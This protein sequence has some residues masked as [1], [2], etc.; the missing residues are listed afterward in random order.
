[1]SNDL[2]PLASVSANCAATPGVSPARRPRRWVIPVIVLVVLAVVAGVAVVVL[3]PWS[4]PVTWT[5]TLDD[6]DTE[7]R[8]VAVAED[9]SVV[10]VGF[11]TVWDSKGEHSREAPVITKLSADGRLL[12]SN[13]MSDNDLHMFNA[14]TIA[15]D[16]NYVVAGRAWKGSG[17][18]AII[19]CLSPDGTVVWTQALGEGMGNEFRGV[20]IAPDGSIVAVGHRHPDYSTGDTAT[21][22]VAKYTMDGT[23]VWMKGIAG[24]TAHD[25]VDF[26][27]VCSNVDGT[28]R[29]VGYQSGSHSIITKIASDGELVWTK[30]DESPASRSV[31]STADG[32]IVVAGRGVWTNNTDTAVATLTPDGDM[33]WIRKEAPW[34]H[35]WGDHT[36]GFSEMTIA[37]SGEI[38]IVGQSGREAGLEGREHGALVTSLKPDGTVNWTKILS[39]YNSLEALDITPAGDIVA[40]GGNVI[41][42]IRSA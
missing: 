37:R 13:T 24:S 4:P 32:N 31:A 20:T 19:Y 8:D 2:A 5:T 22:L 6:R 12:W 10:A 15:P 3:H 25:F 40:V 17:E 11:T 27:S 16:G 39:R 18:Q 21:G 36:V 1:M 28:I 30:L 9:G 33:L 23:L 7:L 14:V 42:N 29:A 35:T 38:V 34:P 26:M 41:V